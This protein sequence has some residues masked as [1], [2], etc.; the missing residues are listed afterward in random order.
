MSVTAQA[1]ENNGSWLAQGIASGI[2]SGAV[3]S[4]LHLIVA[5][6]YNGWKNYESLS[7]NAPSLYA[8]LDK[9][10]LVLWD[11]KYILSDTDFTNALNDAERNHLDKLLVTLEEK[12]VTVK[13]YLLPFLNHIGSTPGF[14]QPCIAE[15]VS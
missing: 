7:A 2:A 1:Q 14:Y 4:A 15:L 12:S 9:V 8:Q 10:V 11:M 3:Y 13:R 5:R 6:L